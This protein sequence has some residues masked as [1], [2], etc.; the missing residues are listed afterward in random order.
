[1]VKKTK[2]LVTQE[3][4]HAIVAFLNKKTTGNCI[5]WDITIA[6]GADPALVICPGTI[7]EDTSSVFCLLK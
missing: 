6:P 2:L 7:V 4:D 1:M 3:S 5:G